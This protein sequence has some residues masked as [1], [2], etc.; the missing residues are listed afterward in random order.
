MVVAGQTARSSAGLRRLLFPEIWPAGARAALLISIAM[1]AVYAG[2]WRAP[3]IAGEQ[4]GIPGAS[5]V[6]DGGLM[7]GNYK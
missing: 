1:M 7:G 2:T 5:A 4:G 3:F 6:Q